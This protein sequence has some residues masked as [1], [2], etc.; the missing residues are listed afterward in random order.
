MVPRSKESIRICPNKSRSPPPLVLCE[1]HR[2][3]RRRQNS[4]F[5]NSIRR[6]FR[7]CSTNL[8]SM[9]K[10]RMMRLWR[11]DKNTPPIYP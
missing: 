3:G 7:S 10:R 5:R 4:Y 8:I 6:P 9:P 11:P 2:L 1:R